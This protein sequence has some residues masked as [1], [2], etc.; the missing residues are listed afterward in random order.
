M[1]ASALLWLRSPSSWPHL[2]LLSNEAVRHP[3]GRRTPA[4]VGGSP[5]PQE[6]QKR[7]PSTG[8][9]HLPKERN[10]NKTRPLC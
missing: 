6:A 8:L 1:R 2:C 4:F 10:G 9:L 3:W 7:R 5:D